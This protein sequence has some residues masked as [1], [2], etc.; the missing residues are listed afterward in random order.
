MEKHYA[1]ESF[2]IRHPALGRILT[3][4]TLDTIIRIA[5]TA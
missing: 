3:Q 2:T 5:K 1:E 4:T